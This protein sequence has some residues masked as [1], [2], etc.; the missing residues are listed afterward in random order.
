MS[1]LWCSR[2]NYTFEQF[3]NRWMGEDVMMLKNLWL[4]FAFVL[5]SACSSTGGDIEAFNDAL[6]PP[7]SSSPAE[8]AAVRI[9]PLDE[10]EIRV[11]GVPE[12]EGVFQID[13]EGVLKLPLIGAVTAKGFTS[14][15][16]AAILEDQLTADYLQEADVTVRLLETTQQQLTVEGAVKNPGIYELP[17]KLTLLQTIALSGGLTKEA[18]PKRVIIFREIE[19]KRHAAGYDLR[20]IRTGDAK[21]PV[22][23]GND[24]VVVDGGNL[25]TTY[26]EFLR[27]VPLLTLF[28]LL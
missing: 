6:P 10:L 16:L 5:V 26:R 9:G 24:L 22:V 21:D 18:N 4:V 28:V 12:L 27:S 17:G 19:G 11:F 20:S 25:N 2:N 14:F 8:T 3:N 23:Y 13:N 7:V 15:E 1:M